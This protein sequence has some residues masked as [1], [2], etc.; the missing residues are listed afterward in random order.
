MVRVWGLWS[1]KGKTTCNMER[2]LELLVCNV[3]LVFRVLGQ[4][5]ELK[6]QSSVVGGVHESACLGVGR[7]L[8]WGCTV[9]GPPPKL[10]KVIA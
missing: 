10:G 3:L 7:S 8:G 6:V 2:K 9:P 1:S 4:D 5:F